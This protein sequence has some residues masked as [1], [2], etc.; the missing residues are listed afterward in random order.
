MY[1]N[2]YKFFSGEY[3]VFLETGTKRLNDLHA[4]QNDKAHSAD[5]SINS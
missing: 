3:Q 1:K 4:A 2:H 5:Y